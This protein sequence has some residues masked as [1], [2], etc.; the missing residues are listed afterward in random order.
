MLSV[1]I[2]RLVQQVLFFLFLDPPLFPLSLSLFTFVENGL[3]DITYV[4]V[5]VCM[6]VCVFVCVRV[7]VCLCVCVYERNGSNSCEMRTTKMKRYSA[8]QCDVMNPV[9]EQVQRYKSEVKKN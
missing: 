8:F 2:C 6:S 3:D 9:R 5:C 1:L 7:C 4:F